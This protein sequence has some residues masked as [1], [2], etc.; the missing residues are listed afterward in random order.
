VAVSPRETWRSEVGDDGT[1]AASP[2]ATRDDVGA[3]EAEVVP[4]GTEL[5]PKLSCPTVGANCRCIGNGST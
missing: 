3:D 2:R 1:G 5:R 4:C